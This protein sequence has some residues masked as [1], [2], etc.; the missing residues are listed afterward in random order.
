[1]SQFSFYPVRRRGVR[2]GSNNHVALIWR[3]GYVVACTLPQPNRSALHVSARA[4]MRDLWQQQQADKY[5]PGMSW[6]EADGYR[7]RT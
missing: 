5:R 1:M 3:A 6:T 7:H 4:L 2:L